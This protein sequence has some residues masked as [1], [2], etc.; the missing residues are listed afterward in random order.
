MT[1]AQHQV[2]HVQVAAYCW[3]IADLHTTQLCDGD[4]T[5]DTPVPARHTA[6]EWELEGARC[7]ITGV[8]LKA[9]TALQHWW[10]KSA[11]R[12]VELTSYRPAVFM[13]LAE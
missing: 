13:D 5:G 9:N 8:Y 7:S 12:S 4:I 11:C 6:V 3:L 1:P 2:Q 10:L